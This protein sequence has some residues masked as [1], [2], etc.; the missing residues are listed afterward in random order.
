MGGGIKRHAEVSKEVP[1]EKKNLPVV[2]KNHNL[3]TNTENHPPKT[4]MPKNVN[5]P[6]NIHKTAPGKHATATPARQ[7]G[8]EWHK[9]SGT[10]CVQTS[11]TAL[12]AG[13]PQSHRDTEKVLIQSDFSLT[14][15]FSCIIHS[16][17]LKNRLENGA[18][19]QILALA[20][21]D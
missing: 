18:K 16:R 2:A 14:F 3:R 21:T 4:E 12:R 11:V 8:A 5:H 9:P 15:D 13:P 10:K 7:T 17:F 20:C 19:V 6:L 1:S